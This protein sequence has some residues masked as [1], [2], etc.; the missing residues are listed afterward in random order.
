[1]PNQSEFEPELIHDTESGRFAI[2]AG[3][4]TAALDYELLADKVVFT[5]TDVPAQLE[6]RGLGGRLVRAGLDWARSEGLSVIPTCAFVA[7]YIG[8]HPEYADPT[9]P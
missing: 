6:G 3:S 4:H 1:M 5:H 8:R 9:R 7:A 2:H